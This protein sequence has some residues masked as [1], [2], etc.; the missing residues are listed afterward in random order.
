MKPNV[1][2]L[3]GAFA[4]VGAGAAA[5]YAVRQKSSIGRGAFLVVLFGVAGLVI[6]N[7]VT[8]FYE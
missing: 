8:K 4:A 1:S 6:G 3:G 7:A 2:Q 5:I